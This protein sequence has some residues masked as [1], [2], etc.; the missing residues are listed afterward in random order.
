[1]SNELVYPV[2]VDVPGRTSTTTLSELVETYGFQRFNISVHP[3]ELTQLFSIIDGSNI[4]FDFSAIGEAVHSAETL[5]YETPNRVL[6]KYLNAKFP[7]RAANFT[8]EWSHPPFEPDFTAFTNAEDTSDCRTSILEQLD[9]NARYFVG[10]SQEYAN[11]QSFTLVTDLSFS[12]SLT[13]TLPEGINLSTFMRTPR[14]AIQN[15]F[16][17]LS[18]GRCIY[19]FTAGE[20]I[21]TTIHVS[22]PLYSIVD[23]SFST[24]GTIVGQ[25]RKT[26]SDGRPS[27]ILYDTTT[28]NRTE[29]PFETISGRSTLSSGT[30]HLSTVNTFTI[31]DT[32]TLS[33][34]TLT[35]QEVLLREETLT[36][37]QNALG[38]SYDFS[39]VTITLSDTGF[40]V[41]LSTGYFTGSAYLVGSGQSITIILDGQ[42]FVVTN[43]GT[44]TQLIGSNDSN[45]YFIYAPG[46]IV[47]ETIAEPFTLLVQSN[48]YETRAKTQPLQ[49]TFDDY[50]P[51][52]V[53]VSYQ[54]DPVDM[55]GR[56]EVTMYNPDGTTIFADVPHSTQ[57]VNNTQPT[58]SFSEN[59]F[60]VSVSDAVYSLSMTYSVSVDTTTLGLG[61]IEQTLSGRLMNDFWTSLNS[62]QT[63]LGSNAQSFPGILLREFWEGIP[64]PTAQFTLP[65]LPNTYTLVYPDRTVTTYFDTE[66]YTSPTY[67]WS[68]TL[69]SQTDFFQYVPEPSNYRFILP[70]DGKHRVATTYTT[71]D[72]LFSNGYLTEETRAFTMEYYDSH[73]MIL[74]YLSGTYSEPHV[75][76][77][78][79]GASG[80][81]LY[82]IL[83]EQ[84]PLYNLTLPE[85]W[86]LV[87]NNGD[88]TYYTSASSNAPAGVYRLYPTRTHF[89]YTW[90][91]LTVSGAFIPGNQ[92]RYVNNIVG[93]ETPDAHTDVVELLDLDTST[94]VEELIEGGTYQFTPSYTVTVDG[95]PIGLGSVTVSVRG[96]NMTECW[97]TLGFTSVYPSE[98]IVPTNYLQS[99][100]EYLP[101]PD[102]TYTLSN[103][104]M[105]TVVFNDASLNVYINTDI[106]Q[107]NFWYS[108]LAPIY[109][110][111]IVT[112]RLTDTSTNIQ[113]VYRAGFD[114]A[115]E[116][117]PPSG[118]T[119][120]LETGMAI[121][122]ITN[123]TESIYFG[124]AEGEDSNVIL[125]NQIAALGGTAIEEPYTIYLA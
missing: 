2:V 88:P 86:E 38:Q 91:D 34:G 50:A 15:E 37:I 97:N 112:I 121:Y 13:L 64:M 30:Y 73:Y 108:Y 9:S 122:Y 51:Y 76:I 44:Y 5:T 113:Y 45:S 6:R 94:I 55:W 32:V 72:I 33:L 106:Y 11:F 71:G 28:S 19:T 24:R 8:A 41:N 75:Y 102:S 87:N 52:T 61:V 117:I 95:T 60:Y 3:D 70:E 124:V 65:S 54:E 92:D 63:Y 18:G 16:D 23:E 25:L 99:N 98:T 118:A 67:G 104:Q 10:P 26:I 123:G 79:N 4:S 68:Q 47:D 83:E 85:T 100:I 66:T 69:T 7:W 53:N 109:G 81:S 29:F 43:T 90:A 21:D 59:L 114:T 46:T 110:V 116:P 39:T 20:R 77:G 120:L 125:S 12:T 35:N 80:E 82:A 14:P 96:S 49:Y 58:I 17:N 22:D 42:A 1:M 93:F 48:A 103:F 111:N 107:A 78:V 57:L 119:L 56:I 27:I 36:A 89:T 101:I 62:I 40:P 84:Y 74:N 105:N 31:L 115:T